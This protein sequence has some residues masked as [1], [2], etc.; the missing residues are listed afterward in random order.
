VLTSPRQQA[1]PRNR[2]RLSDLASGVSWLV[3]VSL[4]GVWRLLRRL[5]FSR[6]Q[7]QPF[8]RS[9]DVAFDAKWREILRAYAETVAQP[10]AVRLIFGD[11]VSYF[12]QPSVAPA[13]AVRGGEAPRAHH[14]P[15]HNTVTRIVAGLDALSGQV[16]YLARSGIEVGT[17][18][19]FLRHLRA[20]YPPAVS[21]RL[22][23]DNWS[24]HV[25]PRTQALAAALGIQLLYLPTYASWLNP[26]E[27]LW[28]WLRQDVIHLHDAARE[29]ATLRDR[30]RTFLD[31]FAIGSP[32]LL[33]YVGLPVD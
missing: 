15:G 23:L 7:A 2:W 17:F 30:V 10:A 29:V 14:L 32:A 20:A 5:G 11:E 6:R 8:V 27:K 22:V 28:R 9:P 33:H 4:S 3:G 13:Y 18:C 31:Q 24:V 1:L 21:L 16:S 12:R 26:I 19:A 25:H